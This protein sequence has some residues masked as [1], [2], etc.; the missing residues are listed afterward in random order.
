VGDVYEAHE[1]LADQYSAGLITADGTPIDDFDSVDDFDVPGEGPETERVK[2]ADPMRPDTRN[3]RY[4]LPHPETGKAKTW[5]R[6]TNFVKLTEDT[7]RLELWERRNV[8]KGAAQLVA[9]GKVDLHE[10]AAMDVKQDRSTLD[11]LCVKA[12]DVAEANKLRDEGTALH[13]SAE[14]ADYAGGD[15]NRVPEHHRAK[16]RLYLDALAAHGL[17]VVPDMIERVILSLRYEVAGKFDRIYRLTEDVTVTDPH[18]RTHLLPAGTNVMS[19]LKTGDSIDLSLPSI[20][21]QLSC[22]EDGVNEHGVFNGRRYD[23][24][25]RVD[26]T[27][28]IVVHLPSTREEVTVHWI[29]LAEG[30]AINDSNL[31]VRAARKIKAKHVS[32]TAATLAAANDHW[33]TQLDA[34]FTVPQLADVAARARS[35]KQWNEELADLARLYAAG[36]RDAAE[37]MGS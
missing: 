3:G 23:D 15:L 20:A 11:K 37:G 19:D 6:V 25:I 12:K 18:G 30:R 29:D 33:A 5:Q 32:Q 31:T 34:C 24:S 16:I 36:I 7:Y 21:A 8:A 35:F 27:F 2:A 9:A 26:H 17:T 14:L 4:P 22:Y 1:A 13:T 10:L 28:G